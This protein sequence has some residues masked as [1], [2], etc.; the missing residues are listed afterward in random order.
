MLEQL[1]S[2]KYIQLLRQIYGHLEGKG[3]DFKV[4]YGDNKVVTYSKDSFD[5][6][7]LATLE[8]GIMDPNKRYKKIELK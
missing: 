8:Y 6:M 1:N 5:A 4:T 2:T 7:A 3:R